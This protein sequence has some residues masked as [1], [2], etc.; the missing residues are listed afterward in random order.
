MDNRGAL[1][2]RV[3]DNKY[4]R[5]PILKSEHELPIAQIVGSNISLFSRMKELVDECYIVVEKMAVSS[6]QYEV[7][8]RMA[9]D[10]LD[11]YGHEEENTVEPELELE[12][13]ETQGRTILL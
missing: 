10:D 13:P 7:K 11:E 8:E 3:L 9:Y 5:S 4:K 1:E 12:Q 6:A 2:R